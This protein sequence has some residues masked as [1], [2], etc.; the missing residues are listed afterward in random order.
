MENFKRSILMIPL[1]L[2][3]CIAA[4]AQSRPAR[5]TV[6]GHITDAATGETLIG[7]GIGAGAVG[8]VAGLVLF[9]ALSRGVCVSSTP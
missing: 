3:G 7:A 2:L 5:C 6:S 1:L 9:K 4:L 8:A